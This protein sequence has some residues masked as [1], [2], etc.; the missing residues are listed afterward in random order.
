[1]NG[2]GKLSVHEIT[3][4]KLNYLVTSSFPPCNYPHCIQIS[5]PVDYFF[6]KLNFLK[7]KSWCSLP[8]DCCLYELWIVFNS[9]FPPPLQ[10]HFPP[11]FLWTL[12]PPV[13]TQATMIY[14]KTC[15]KDGMG[16]LAVYFHRESRGHF[17]C[18]VLWMC[19]IHCRW[20]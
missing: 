14:Y 5:L 4:E 3:E 6:F 7:A 16:T 1:M 11:M 13:P 19:S 18:L 12:R 17:R 9:S 2:F 15:N 20:D 8:G 10:F